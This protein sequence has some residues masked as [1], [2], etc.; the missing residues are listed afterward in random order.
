[1]TK[2]MTVTQLRKEIFDVVEA[3]KVNQ[4]ITDI[5]LH[6]EV[7]A[8]IVPKK[9]DKFDWDKYEK[10]MEKAL[11]YLRKFDWSDVLEVRKKSKVRRYRGW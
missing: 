1:M 4:Q 10:D 7:V 3:A 2:T 8:S 11:I 6:G 5:M 9:V